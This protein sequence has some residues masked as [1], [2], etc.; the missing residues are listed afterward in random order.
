MSGDDQHLLRL[1]EAVREDDGAAHHLVGVLR[2]DAEPDRQRDG[3]VELR[4]LELLHERERV[5]EQVGLVLDLL[6]CRRVFLA[7]C[8]HVNT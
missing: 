2:I 6:L 3:L 4:E 5:C 7:V 1:A 8:S